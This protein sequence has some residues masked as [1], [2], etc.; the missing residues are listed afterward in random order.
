MGITNLSLGNLTDLVFE[1][2]N[3]QYGAYQLRSE[4]SNRLLVA[5][6]S[7]I[8]IIVL[9]AVS[10]LIADAF[11]TPPE[12]IFPDS[13]PDLITCLPPVTTIEDKIKP[14]HPPQ[15]KPPVPLGYSLSGKP[16]DSTDVK[17]EPQDLAL[18]P[19][20]PNG[21]PD[22]PPT[23][24]P[25][26]ADPGVGAITVK[27]A[28]EPVRVPDE[29][30]VFNGDLK[31]W[32]AS[33]LN[34]PEYAKELGTQGTVH[35]EF[36]IDE[37]GNVSNVKVLRDIGDGCGEAALKTVMSMPKWKPGRKNGENVKVYYTLPVKFSL[38]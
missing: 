12:I 19:G 38:R 13:P 29:N 1:N 25:E 37:E 24:I 16:V 5:F 22:V 14:P 35:L 3:R 36:I 10:P 27:K 7:G 2:R 26:P 17:N 11:R 15:P 28:K 6:V 9:L 34:Y 4:Y 18:L 8:S 31:K 30:P 32:L 21:N 23:I 20:D 33:R